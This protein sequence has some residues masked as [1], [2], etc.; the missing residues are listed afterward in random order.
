[1]RT[2][3]DAPH[4]ENRKK[5]PEENK[6]HPF[7]FLI[8][9][10]FVGFLAIN[11][12][13][14]WKKKLETQ[15]LQDVI[16]S[17]DIEFLLNGGAF[18]DEKTTN[19][20]SG[21]LRQMGEDFVS[22][23]TLPK[24]DSKNASKN[25]NTEARDSVHKNKALIVT[26]S[27]NNFANTNTSILDIPDY[28]RD[29]VNLALRDIFIYQG[30]NG[31]ESWRLKAEWATLRQTTSVLN[32]SQ[33]I[34]LYRTGD[35]KPSNNTANRTSTEIKPFKITKRDENNVGEKTFLENTDEELGNFLNNSTGNSAKN[36]T[37]IT[38]VTH[39]NFFRNS[40]EMLLVTAKNGLV[41]D[42]NSKIHLTE[43]V[44]AKQKNN[45]VE[46]NTLNYNDSTRIATFPNFSKFAGVNLKGYALRLDWDLNTNTLTGTNGVEITWY[47]AK[48][49]K[50]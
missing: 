50:P 21:Q 33:P 43:D 49:E 35:K 45:Y 46:S 14:A 5:A 44:L 3:M 2:R 22:E 24:K 1:M 37:A 38:N 8:F 13:N 23:Q 20:I 32:L 47:P 19:E 30:S 15:T 28:S 4:N 27:T 39:A 17:E 9:L 41:F 6:I 12:W 11:S 34:L 26:D 7:L 29:T 31:T 16:R 40:S 10:F 42:N 36:S 48:D 18:P 25:K